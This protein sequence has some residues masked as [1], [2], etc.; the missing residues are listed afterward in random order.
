MFDEQNYIE[1]FCE[2]Y[3]LSCAALARK[4]EVSPQVL[5]QWAKS[6]R[7]QR[8]ISLALGELGRELDHLESLNLPNWYLDETNITE[9]CHKCD[10]DKN[11]A[12]EELVAI[13]ES[14]KNASCFVEFIVNEM[15][16][17]NNGQAACLNSME[18]L[19]AAQY[20]RLRTKK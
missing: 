6:E 10:W 3:N 9:L 1:S 11:H 16:L 18:L 8:L 12:V 17:N 2:R 15:L 20:E 7:Y 13:G 5:G 4:L 19:S 14:R